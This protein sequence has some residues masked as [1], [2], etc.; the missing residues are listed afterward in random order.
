MPNTLIP[1]SEGGS[2]PAT[3]FHQSELSHMDRVKTKG[4]WEVQSHWAQFS[5]MGQEKSRLQ[6]ALGIIS[7]RGNIGNT[8]KQLFTQFYGVRQAQR[9]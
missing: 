4:S 6:Q 8:G 5:S 7:I 2:Y 9:D 3:M 1:R